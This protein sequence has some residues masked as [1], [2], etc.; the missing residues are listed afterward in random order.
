MT[1]CVNRLIQ[2]NAIKPFGVTNLESVVYYCYKKKTTEQPKY[3]E[4]QHYIQ[5]IAELLP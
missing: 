4:N 1:F 3:S 5:A 2:D